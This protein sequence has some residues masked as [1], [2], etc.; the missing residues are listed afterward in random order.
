MTAVI[1]ASCAPKKEF[2][3]PVSQA[4]LSAEAA[5]KAAEEAIEDARVA[6][7]DVADAEE[8]LVKA[9][10]ALDEGD[11]AVAHTQADLARRN[12]L[13]AKQIFLAEKHARE[14]EEKKAEPAR[15]AIAAAEEAIA[16]AKSRNADVREAETLLSEAKNAFD[17]KNYALATTKANQAKR[18]ALAAK[19]IYTV[20][21]WQQDRDCLWNIAK[22]KDIYNDPWKWKKIYQA[23]R[24]KIKDPDL[25]Y[26][27][28]ELIIP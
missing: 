12:A 23:N 5:I 22:K 4:Q 13:T 19:R 16:K 27:G 24:D 2:V 25:I 21:T 1:A 14:E 8:L 28:Q 18:L 11:F 17:G 10:D 3:P 20:G 26:P 6:G 7:V 15:K 9:K